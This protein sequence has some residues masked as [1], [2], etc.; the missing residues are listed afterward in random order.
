[1]TT[2]KPKRKP[3]IEVT[4]DNYGLAEEARAII[5]AYKSTHRLPTMLHALLAMVKIAEKHAK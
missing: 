3:F 4:E 1:M 5:G 2:T